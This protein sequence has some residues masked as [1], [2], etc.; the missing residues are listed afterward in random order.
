MSIKTNNPF[1]PRVSLTVDGVILGTGATVSA[2]LADSD[3]QGVVQVLTSQVPVTWDAGLSRWVCEFSAAETSKLLKDPLD[4]KSEI[5]YT[6]VTLQYV[7][8]GEG[9]VEFVF[10]VDRGAM[11]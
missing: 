3:G 7:V 2:V 5:K 1:K 11:V 9:T 8:Q 6:Q 10:A 4:P